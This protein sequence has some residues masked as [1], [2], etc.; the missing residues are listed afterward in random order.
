MMFARLLVR[1]LR[2][3]RGR[4]AVALLALT[5]G[6][7]VCSALLNLHLDAERKLTREFRSLGANVVVAPPGGA[8]ASAAE[9]A[10]MDEAALRV[11]DAWRTD[12]VVAA[13]PYLYLVARAGE[14]RSVIVAGTRLDEARR[15]AS[16][17]SID[18]AWVATRDDLERCLVGRTAAR[19]LRLAP[20]SRVDLRYAGRSRTLAVAGVIDAGGSEDGQIFVNLPVAQE[21]AALPGRIG[22]VQMSVRGAPDAIDSLIAGLRDRLPGFDILPVRQIAEAEGRLLGRIRNLI[23]AT[24]ALI[25]GLTVLSVLS[26]TTALAL[27]RRS[28]VGLMKALG[29]STARVVRLFLA[30]VTL[31]G[32]A[33]G[34]LGYLLGRLLCVWIGRSVFGTPIAFRP[35]VLPLT[36]ALM[37]AVALAGALPIRLLGR[38]P[39]AVILRG[40]A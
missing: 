2:A 7:A 39:P 8:G 15:M 30:E 29:G 13:A 37:M 23:L 4:L 35:E 3:G 12:Q 40:E 16:W 11:I 27:E 14:G 18:G 26:T 19:Q 36:V 6:A 34:V 31:L 10:L 20:G 28:D 9:P 24:V 17:W 22:L 21:L 32:V 38:V 33:G 1:V 25:L 5:S